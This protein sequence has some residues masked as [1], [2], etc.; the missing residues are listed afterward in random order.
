MRVSDFLE[1]PFPTEDGYRLMNI[2]QVFSPEKNVYKLQLIFH[3][4]IDA[5]KKLDTPKLLRTHERLGVTDT[6][7]VICDVAFERLLTV[8]SIWWNHGDPQAVTSSKYLEHCSISDVFLE[9]NMVSQTDSSVFNE[10]FGYPE[11]RGKDS[12]VKHAG[13]LMYELD[14]TLFEHVPENNEYRFYPHQPKWK[15]DTIDFVAFNS[16]EVHRYFF[17]S[18]TIALTNLNSRMLIPQFNNIH[19]PET[20]CLFD[21]V[22]SKEENGIH[23]VYL[24][25]RQD[26]VDS[27]TLGNLA[28]YP[29]FRDK[30]RKMQNYL[31]VGDGKENGSRYYMFSAID[32]LPINRFSRLKG[33]AFR[34]TRKDGKKG[35]YF[36][37]IDYCSKSINH[38]YLAMEPIKEGT[39]ITYPGGGGNS[40]GLGTGPGEPHEVLDIRY[41]GG[42]NPNDKPLSI[43]ALGLEHLLQP[44][45]DIRIEDPEKYTL[46]GDTVI[47]DGNEGADG[48]GTEGIVS[49]PGIRDKDDQGYTPVIRTTVEARDYFDCFPEILKEVEL[50]LHKAGLNAL[51]NF[52]TN[53]LLTSKIEEIVICKNL[54]LSSRPTDHD[55][56]LYVGVFQIKPERGDLRYYY[57]FEKTSTTKTVSRTWLYAQDRYMEIEQDKLLEKIHLY[58]YEDEPT[59]ADRKEPNNKFNHKQSESVMVDGKPKDVPIQKQVAIDLQIEKITAR[60]MKTFVGEVLQ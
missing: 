26:L 32:G 39:I 11:R 33:Y 25:N 57:L 47:P 42:S 28:Y 52:Y 24:R 7:K 14:K 40:G 46:D 4:V 8:G 38:S 27:D 45:Q 48:E 19:D 30:V 34:V 5:Q 2:S 13:I 22:K 10:D 15:V 35:L 50:N 21:P 41:G 60:I 3:R 49:P 23:K 59:A 18:K 54:K 36:V 51:L 37:E 9:S 16:Y 20:N 43:D 56:L 1:K 29:A 44:H 31:N 58:L 53:A 12:V 6:F 17:S 55:W